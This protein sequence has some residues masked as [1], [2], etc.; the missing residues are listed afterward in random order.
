M[1]RP[2]YVSCA[3]RNALAVQILLDGDADPGLRTRIDEYQM[4][5]EMAQS[6][7]LAD[8]AALLPR[9]G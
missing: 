2:H 8:I 3:H 9:N 5:L 7:G 1:V 6:A 4:P